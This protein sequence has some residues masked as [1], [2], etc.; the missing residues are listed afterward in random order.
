MVARVGGPGGLLVKHL[1][2]WVPAGT[3]GWDGPFGTGGTGPPTG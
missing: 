3:S 1:Y 2:F